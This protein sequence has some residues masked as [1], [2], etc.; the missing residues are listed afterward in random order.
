MTT[1]LSS[2]ATAARVVDAVKI[3]G[4]GETEVRAWTG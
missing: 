1:T 3:Y 2:T 4:T